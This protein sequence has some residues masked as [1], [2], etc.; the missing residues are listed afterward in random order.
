MTR[1]AVTT[2]APFLSADSLAADR[3]EHLGF[4]FGDKGTHT[5]RTMMLSD[6]T[7]LL[8]ATSPTARRDEYASAIVDDNIL[9]KPTTA[10]R[11]LSLQRLTELYGLDVSVAVFRVLRRLWDLDA[12]A[13]PLLS[14][15]VA[16]A[17]D[18]LLAA[19]AAAVI[20]LSVG[21]EYNRDTM[22][23]ALRAATGAR[24]SD[25]T[26]NKVARNTASSW[27]QSGHL[28]GRTFKQREGGRHAGCCI[29]GALSRARCR[30]Q[31]RGLLD[32]PWVLLL[33]C[34]PPTARS[35]AL[36]AKRQNLI[37]LRSSGDVPVVDV[38]RLDPFFARR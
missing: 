3:A 6:V 11:R 34:D 37:D 23:S 31:R 14:L 26:L 21:D 1:L 33:D 9:S 29:N 32:S 15:L 4:R 16:I 35:L 8:S 22:R 28:I 5:S 20:P 7:A 13:R 25:Q 18:P 30:I 24:L 27:T 36:E 12:S 2:L 19:S 38:D 17:R 10:T